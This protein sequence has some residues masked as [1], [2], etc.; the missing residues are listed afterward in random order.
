MDNIVSTAFD[1]EFEGWRSSHPRLW[2][3]T[4]DRQTAAEFISHQTERI[5][6][7]QLEAA[8]RIIVSQQRV[9]AGVDAVATAV[10]QVADGLEGLASAFE[11]GFSEMV[12]QL[13]QQRETLKQILEVLRAPL[14][15]RAKELRRRA[16]DAYGNGWI[17]DALS[18]FL[19]SE[20]KN[21]YDFT[22]HH[23]L[24]NIY[25]YHKAAP[26]KALEYYGKAAK[27]ATPKS[28]YHA[29]IALLHIAEIEYIR[30][31][32]EK[33][34]EAATRAIELSPNLAELHFARARYCA[35]LGRC[36]EAIENLGRAIE[37]DRK[38]CLKADASEDFSGMKGE[39]RAFF[40]R[41]RNEAQDRAREEVGIS[42]GLIEYADS[43]D[44]PYLAEFIQ[45][46]TVHKRAK[47]LLGRAS[48]FDCWDATRESWNAQD[49]I[50]TTLEGHVS[51]QISNACKEN[52]TAMENLD[53]RQQWWTHWLLSM[54]PYIAFVVPIHE[55][56]SA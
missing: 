43:Y 20:T 49:L 56:L 21:R 8:D 46:R 5:T 18:D 48:L 2:L 41:L 24:G 52:T 22:V 45:P 14:D 32:Y 38:Y 34:Y 1:R 28:P 44:L 23:Y 9:E 29:S 47:V 17:D 39:L 30:G 36:D 50:L 40:E 6:R 19:E 12:W 16:E 10:E 54:T 33:A 26:D 25:F 13:E 7:A 42:D 4:T 15:T 53:R 31:D 55:F 27:Y 37:D 51:S 35:K 3:A 11:F